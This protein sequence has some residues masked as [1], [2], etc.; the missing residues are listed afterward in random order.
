VGKINR[1]QKPR[2]AFR[3]IAGHAPAAEERRTTRRRH[4]WRLLAI[5]TLIWIAYSNSFQG[6]LVFDNIPI[7]ENDPRIREV[8]LPNVKSIL[9][10]EY[11]YVSIGAGLYRPATTLSYLVNYAV[12][13]NGPH[14]AGYHVVN[15]VLHEINVT[16]V[17]ALGVLILGGT[18]PAL[19]LAAI[20]GL[21]P[22]LTESVANIV[23]R[24]DLLAALGVLAGL[25]CHVRGASATGRRRAA[26][27]AGL[28]AAQAA[29]LF[30]KESAAVLPGI[31][32]LHDL[33]WPGRTTWR[34]RLP[35][36]VILALPFAAFLYG[37]SGLQ[38]PMRIEFAENPLA[39]AGFWA[40]RLTA[41][42]VV[43]K[44]L[45]LFFWPAHLSADYSYNAVPVFGWRALNWEDA[46]ALF[47]LAVCLGAGLLVVL[48]AFRWRRSGRP[49]LFFLVFFVIALLPASNLI[50][51]IGSIMAERFLYLP[52]V[53]LAGGVVAAVYVLAR[54]LSLKLPA[55]ALGLVCV[56]LAARTYT[57]N[58]DWKDERSLWTSAAEVCPE[59]A[60]PHF[61]L[62]TTLAR[63]PGMMPEA[64]D[65]FRAALRISPDSADVHNNLGMALSKIPGRLPEA[66]A[67]L[68]VALRINPDSF[69]VHNNLG[70]ALV[71][72]PGRELESIAEFQAALRTKPGSPQL[73]NDLGLAL[74]RVPGRLPEAIAQFQEA[75][76]ID[77][78]ISEAHNN[79]GM[80]LSEM[81]DQLPRA[82]AEFQK[83]VRTNPDSPVPHNNLGMALARIPEREPEAIAEFQAALRIAPDYAEAHYNL[84][85]VLSR[86]PGRQSE[87]IA[88]LEAGQRISPDPERLPVL[89]Q[90]R[91]KR[92]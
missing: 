78:D 47:A 51:L 60:R 69:E 84:G 75:L 67:E 59:S 79:L 20:W 44:Y 9:T 29:G 22:L 14:P 27:L 38:A 86:M 11:S 74:A 80:A 30:S 39:S 63:L 46:K 50:I 65:E 37:R 53:G 21:H 5:W 13:G 66:I 31:M 73:H 42:K 62:A 24:A 54:R 15:L 4:G 91:S 72:V 61:N 34:Q 55:A 32:L 16:L 89:E 81:P 25:L 36:Y 57:R 71:N 7:I 68:Q 40:A 92:R 87:A 49:I 48:L 77:P 43:G 18:A 64:I 10:G 82:I 52:S 56:A 8:T 35:A 41:I 90:L 19:A 76:S 1:R 70:L 12:L 26:W 85:T 88:E 3:P 2:D 28:A 58:F 33:I 17:Y 83:A 23:G 6:T 45:W